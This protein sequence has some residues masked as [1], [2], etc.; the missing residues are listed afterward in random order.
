MTTI[1]FENDDNSNKSYQCGQ[2]FKNSKNELAVL[3]Q[4]AD[5]KVSLIHINE[6]DANRWDEAIKVKSIPNITSAEF[7]KIAANEGDDWKL[8]HVNITVK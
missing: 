3:T 8:V 4:V 2:W 6:N 7:N 5:H 1:I